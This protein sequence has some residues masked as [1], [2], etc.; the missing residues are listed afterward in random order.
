MSRGPSDVREADVSFGRDHAVR[1]EMGRRRAP[2]ADDDLP[3]GYKRTEVGVIPEDWGVTTIGEVYSLKNGIN[4]DKSAY[5]IGTPFVNVLEAIEHSHLSCSSIPGKVQVSSSL[6]GLFLVRYGDLLF[7]RTSE[8][9]DEVGLAAVYLDSGAAVFG[10]FVIRGRQKEQ[11]LVP[12]YSGYGL[13]ASMVRSQIISQGQGAVRANIGQQ[14]LRRV[15]IPIPPISEQR[16]IAE[17][18]S[19]ADRLIESLD[20]LI[21]KK[22]YVKQAAMQQ[23]L[24][25]KTRLPGFSGEW[26]T[27]RLGEISEIVMGQSPPSQYY[28]IGGQ[29][30]PL[31]QGNLDIKN[32]SSIARVW[33]IRASKY[34][35]KG[36]LLL[37]VRAPVGIVGVA[38]GAVCL[39]RGVCAVKPACDRTFL[40]F[41]LTNA[42]ERWSLLEQGST[43][44]SANSTQ[45]RRFPLYIPLDGSEQTA[46]ATVL[47]DIDAEI[48]AL[49]R[50][51]D[52][53]KAVKQGMMQELLTG[54]IR[55]V[56]P[57]TKKAS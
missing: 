41:A 8:T 4:A 7:N 20:K 24:T 40:F 15:L 32:G 21:A 36:D 46:I 55:L 28:N 29:G 35:Q 16:A 39:G 12:E 56:E 33:T 27:K 6:I 25:G 50:R 11:K 48:A 53:A 45:I 13:R 54:R 14:N 31:I 52:K 51:R 30:L 38:S 47:S 23:L 22:R 44:T 17:A 19:D 34:A 42:E 5:G 9:Y 3:E 49:E 37:T 43:F 57:D 10:G 2:P 1:D 26:A 18:L